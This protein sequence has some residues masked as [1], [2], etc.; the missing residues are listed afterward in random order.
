MRR[1]APRLVHHLAPAELAQSA[2]AQGLAQV[3]LA[4]T[5]LLPVPQALE[6]EV[7]FD[8]L[9]HVLLACCAACSGRLAAV[10]DQY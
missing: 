5:G 2:T 3:Q 9:R 1:D 4:G 6:G 8:D 7:F 10:S